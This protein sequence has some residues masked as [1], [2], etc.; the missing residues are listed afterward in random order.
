MPSMPTNPPAN[1][2]GIWRY[3]VGRHAIV[4]VRDGRWWWCEDVP[5]LERSLR[6]WQTN[7]VVDVE[8]IDRWVQ[9]QP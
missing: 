3:D 4:R 1:D 7:P 2:P 8:E 9:S 6:E 5:E